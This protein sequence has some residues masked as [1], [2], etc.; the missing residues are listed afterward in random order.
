MRKRGKR[1]KREKREKEEKREKREK[2]RIIPIIIRS[3]QNFSLFLR[4]EKNI[5]IIFWAVF[6]VKVSKMNLFSN[7]SRILEKK[8][9]REI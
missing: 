9:K 8:E 6:R 7:V 3:F 1:E 4:K 5:I 2:E